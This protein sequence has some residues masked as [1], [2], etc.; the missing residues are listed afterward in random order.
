[1]LKNQMVTA[2]ASDFV[3]GAGNWKVKIKGVKDTSSQFN[4]NVDWLVAGVDYL[5][6]GNTIPYGSWQSY[7][8][9]V[10][11]AGGAPIPY[12]YFSIYANGTSVLLS[13]NATDPNATI[14]NP[15]WV[16]LNAEGEYFFYLRS[17]SSTS[18]TF[19]VNVAVGTTLGQKTI[20][21]EAP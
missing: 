8:I 18:E 5:S 14:S 9:K 12:S 15:G 2:G 7:T 16:Q 3:D 21:Q 10:T 11:S 6:S 1:E 19:V 17:T 13:K 4:V 20:V